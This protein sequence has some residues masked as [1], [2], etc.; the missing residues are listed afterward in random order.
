MVVVFS[1]PVPESC[2]VLWSVS[3]IM[4]GW[5]DC[6]ASYEAWTTWPSCGFVARP[7]D[8]SGGLSA[9]A[10]RSFLAGP[11]LARVVRPGRMWRACSLTTTL[12]SSDMNRAIRLTCFCGPPTL[13]QGIHTL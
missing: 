1:R 10:A 6:P 13:S 11:V 5:C 3:G 2:S 8:V 4:L 9:C 12:P 7:V